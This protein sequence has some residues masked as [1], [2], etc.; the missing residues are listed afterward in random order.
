MNLILF[1][2]EEIKRFFCDGMLNVPFSDERGAHMIDVLKLKEGDTVKIG[3]VGQSK[4]GKMQVSELKGKSIGLVKTTEVFDSPELNPVT[5]ILGQV[6]PICMKRILRDVVALGLERVILT[7]GETCEK[8]YANAGIYKTGEYLQYLIDGAM[9]AGSTLISQVD[10]ASSV[11]QALE[12]A[13]D[14]PQRLLFD[15]TMNAEPLSSSTLSRTDRTVVAIGPERGW[16]DAERT[17]FVEYGFSPKSLGPRIM[18]TETAVPAGCGVL[19]SL[20]G[21][22]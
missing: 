22:I 13:G 2:P 11:P 7:L 20:L 8:S 5:L 21:E 14:C 1:K 10:F 4:Y 16:T 3:V 18:R 15:N 6:R 12:M 19:L 17:A 9:Q